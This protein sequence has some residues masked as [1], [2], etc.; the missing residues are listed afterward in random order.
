MRGREEVVSALL[1]VVVVAGLSL[2]SAGAEADGGSLRRRSLHQPFFPIDSTPPPGSD[3]SILPPP[4]PPDASAAAA[5][6][7]GGRSSP[8]VTNAIAIALAT[9]LVALAV[10]FYSCFLLWRRR[11]DGGDGGGGG[12]L[13][14]AKPA[15]SGAGAAA[16]RVASDVG[17]SARHQRSP[18]PSSTASD[19]I[20]L[21][22]LTTMVEVGRHRPQSPD[23]RPLALVKQPSPDLRPLPP[24]KRPA[25]Q[26]PPPPAST[27]PMTTTGDSSD[28]EDQATFYTA[29]KTAKSSFSRSTSQ[30]SALEQTAPQ[31]PAPVPVPAPAPA[32]TP[33]PPPQSNPPRPVRPPPPPPPPRQR[34]L[35]PMPT[36]SPPPAVLASLALTNS[37]ESS[38]Q[39]RGGENPDGHGGRARPPKPPILKPLHW[40]KLRAISGRTTVWDQVNSS[41]SFRVDEA[42]MESLFLNNTGGAGN[43]DQAARRGG[44]GKQESR[45]LDPKRLQNVAIMLKALNVTSDDVIGALIHGSGDLGSEFYETLA[46]MAPTKEEELRLKDYTGDISKLDPAESFLKDVL[47]VPFAFKRVDALLYRANFDTEM[48]FLKNSFGTLEAACAD[49]RSSKLF[50]KLLDAVLK[51]GN[52]MNDGT[53]RGEARAFKLDTLLKLADIKSTDGK[54]TVLHF[55]VQEI[56]RSEG[57]SS[58]QTAVVNPGIT[59]KEQFKKDGLKVLAGLS[60]ELSNVKRAATL[61]MDT[62]IGNVSRLKT[63]LEKVKLVMQLKETCPDQDSSEKFFDAMDAFLGRSRVEIESVKAAGESAQQRVKETTEYFH[64]DAT[65]EEPHP[66]RIFMVVSDF[67]STLD[68]VCRDVGRTPERVMMGSGKSFHVSAGTSFPPRRHEQ[69]REPSSSDEDSSSS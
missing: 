46:K 33:P 19:A 22:P 26:P 61:D 60:S 51:T 69:R 5:A 30:R 32:P 36:E 42:A 41:D 28:E 34:L 11:S 18:P 63:D 29:P 40:D 59:S 64:G 8:S 67:L 66:L 62:L 2:L 47:D 53:N 68:R 35:R 23:L 48:D 39:D 1:A 65:K 27:P 14:A 4:P 13:R 57:L 3:D 20:Y 15:R 25:P 16:V 6:K 52:R 10:A 7:G 58:D 55:V 45:L 24:L 56:I 50:M 38:V 49:L 44:A 17:S 21:D 43:S 54:T 9:G 12:G 31:P 37:P